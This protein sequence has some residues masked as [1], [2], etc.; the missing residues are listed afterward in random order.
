MP[1]QEIDTSYWALAFPG[2]VL[3]ALGPDMSFA[4]ASMFITP[5]VPKTHQGPPYHCPEPINSHSGCCRLHDWDIVTGLDGGNLDHNALHAIW[6]L[7][8]AI[9]LG[10]LICVVFV[11][12]PGSEEK[13]HG[14]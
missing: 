6:W 1:P 3:S 7:S 11:R 13:E 4:A 10:V 2:F 9:V 5:N 14:S 8:L 12:V